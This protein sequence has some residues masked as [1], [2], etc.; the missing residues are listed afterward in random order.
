MA[1]VAQSGSPAAYQP[2]RTPWGDPDLQGVWPTTDFLGTP[3]QRPA[4]F[5]TRNTLTEAEFAARAEQARKQLDTDN[6]EFEVETADTSNAGEVGSATSPPPHWLERGKATRQASFVVDPP[7]GRVPALTA[8]G[9]QRLAAL[10][11]A[12]A[13]ARTRR[14]VGRPEPVGPLPDPRPDRVDPADGLQRRQRDHPGARLRGAA[15]RDDP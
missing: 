4:E 1:L 11:E 15:Q 14:L 3:F 9:R 10:Q 5:G 6:A 13:R 12:A 2:P 7:D 8:A